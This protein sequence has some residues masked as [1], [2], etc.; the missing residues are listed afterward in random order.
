MHFS[1]EKKR[2]ELAV[3]GSNPNVMFPNGRHLVLLRGVEGSHIV[4]P[5]PVWAT[6][7]YSSTQGQGQSKIKWGRRLGGV[8]G[9]GGDGERR[10]GGEED[11]RG[12]EKA[13]QMSVAPYRIRVLAALWWD[14]G[15]QQK[16]RGWK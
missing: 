2:G 14:T 1:R 12:G 5:A 4:A 15:L 6:T 13:E 3:V 11:R 8:A 7:G 9:G 10:R 16:R